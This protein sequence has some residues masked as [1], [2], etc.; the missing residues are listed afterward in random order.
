MRTFY[1]NKGE[2]NEQ[3]YYAKDNKVIVNKETGVETVIED[4]IV[5]SLLAQGYVEETEV[6]G[7]TK[8]AK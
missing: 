8:K 1:Y 2:E 5:P 6:V 7:V 3:L 4:P